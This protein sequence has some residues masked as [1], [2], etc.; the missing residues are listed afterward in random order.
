MKITT[1]LIIGLLLL[2]CENQKEVSSL[3]PENWQKRAATIKASDSLVSGTSY[4]SVYSQI[5]GKNEHRTHDLTATISMRNTN[6][7]AT[8]YIESAMYY[9]TSG[10][11]IRSYFENPIFLAPMEAVEIII[12][13]MKREGGSGG[14]F[15][16]KWLINPAANEPLFEAVMISASGQQGLSFTTRGL[17]I[18]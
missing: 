8:I 3:N 14:N 16:F 17:R 18:E 5:Y 6:S 12:D 11:L 13:T 10:K 9:D 1:A 15:I 4:L 2:S 7:D